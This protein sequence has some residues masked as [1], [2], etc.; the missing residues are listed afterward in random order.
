VQA[1][2]GLQRR[3]DTI[4]IDPCIPTVWP[5]YMMEWTI[6]GTRYR[7]VVENPNHRS[8]GVASAALDGVA[9][10]AAAIP[11]VIDGG[12]HEVRVVLGTAVQA[13]VPMPAPG[14]AEQSGV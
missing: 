14:L 4:S 7:F 11:L 12:E 6:S 13:E 3:G 10:D 2:L 8:R 5:E 1:L 9:V